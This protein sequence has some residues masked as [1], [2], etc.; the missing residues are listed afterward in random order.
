MKKL[1]HVIG[2]LIIVVIVTTLLSSLVVLIAY[3]VGWLLRLLLPLS[4]FEATLLIIIA[5]IAVGALIWNILR[6]PLP[7]DIS[8]PYYDEEDDDDEEE[9]FEDEE[10]ILIIDP[11]AR[12]PCGSGR[13]YKNCHGKK[14]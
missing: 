9:E 7:F 6:L 13:K 3:G 11:D 8:P 2:L 4:P 14:Q 12:C 5:G 1:L 10:D